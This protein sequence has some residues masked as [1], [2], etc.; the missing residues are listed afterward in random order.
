MTAVRRIGPD[1]YGR[2]RALRVAQ[3]TAPSV[4][5]RRDSPATLRDW[6][7]ACAGAV[8]LLGA[9]A[10]REW[11]LVLALLALVSVGLSVGGTL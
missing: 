2:L 1:E 6:L 10:G 3:L 9:W 5:V 7:W 11:L 4:T 8:V